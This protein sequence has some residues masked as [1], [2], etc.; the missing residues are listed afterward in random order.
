MG[1]GLDDFV[2]MSWDGSSR[3]GRPSAGSPIIGAAEAQHAAKR[4][5]YG[6]TRVSPHDAGAF[7]H[8]GA[9]VVR[10]HMHAASPLEPGDVAV[11]LLGRRVPVEAVSTYGGSL[12]SR[13]A[14]VYVFRAR[15]RLEVMREP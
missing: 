2:N 15:A 1:K 12:S 5:M 7:A 3:N 14:G 11:D 9:S 8:D 10:S 13:A 6:N 4:D